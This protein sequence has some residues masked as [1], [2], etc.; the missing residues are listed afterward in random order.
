MLAT[1][2][3]NRYVILLTINIVLLIV[4]VFMDMTPALL[5]F[6]PIF[7]P[8]VT[9]MGVDPVHFGVIMIYNLAIG[10]VTPPVGTVLFV[11]CSITG[12]SITRVIR[13]LLPIF[14][15]QIVGLLLVTY[16]PSISLAL[17]RMFGV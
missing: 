14:A 9:S 4:G 1:I 2:S 17:P 6:T 13:P 7:Y 11:A 12:E 5:I 8:V 15:L 16:F 3:D 10:V